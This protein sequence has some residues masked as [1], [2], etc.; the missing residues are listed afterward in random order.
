M[1]VRRRAALVVALLGSILLPA[2]AMAGLGPPQMTASG[3]FGVVALIDNPTFSGGICFYDPDNAQD[4]VRMKVRRPIVFAYDRRPGRLDSQ[5]VGWRYTIQVSDDLT[6]WSNL[7][8]S[9]IQTRT[10]T[11]VT[12][13][14]FR[15][16]AH[17]FSSTHAA[18]RARVQVYWYRSGAI[19][20]QATLYP[21]YYGIVTNFTQF[22]PSYCPD[23]LVS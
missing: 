13:A 17:A 8:T 19:D 9:P 20:G 14:D 5:T 7:Y 12:N 18:Y 4:L 16:M 3:R 21:F 2:S 11:D 15:P 6:T 22:V 10:A 1:N 23:P